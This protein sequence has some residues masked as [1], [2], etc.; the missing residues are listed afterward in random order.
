MQ[1]PHLR[2]AP[3]QDSAELEALQADV[4][5]F[6]A[7]IGLCLAAIF[8]LLQSLEPP[9][10]AVAA[11]ANDRP[12][13][14]VAELP[15]EPAPE[16]ATTLMET[17]APETT[18]QPGVEPPAALLPEPVPG[19]AAEPEPVAVAASPPLPPDVEGFSLSF[20]SDRAMQQLLDQGRIRLFATGSGRYWRYTP[21]SGSFTEADAPGQY[22]V[23]Q[24]ATVPPELRRALVGAA[25]GNVTWGVVL[26]LDILGQLDQL[27]NSAPGGELI[28]AASG[29][30]QRR[31]AGS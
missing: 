18:A 31:P 22:H 30:V 10:P 2:R 6:V 3:A 29:R 25:A 13:E 8:S 27:M 9:L 20:A 24:A 14:P 21:G 11:A 19:S 17:T 23:M 16:V 12:A 1:P 7:I 5:R 15:V 28:I 26:P 4:M